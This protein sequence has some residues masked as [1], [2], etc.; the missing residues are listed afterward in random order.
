MQCYFDQSSSKR[1]VINLFAGTGAVA[2]PLVTAA[3]GHFENLLSI[4][5]TGEFLFCGEIP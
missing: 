5:I 4:A 2:C 3:A 1:I